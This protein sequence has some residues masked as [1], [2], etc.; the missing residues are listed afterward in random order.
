MTTPLVLMLLAAIAAP[1][2]QANRP[3]D[4]STQRAAVPEPTPQAMEYYRSGNLLWVVWHVTA[5]AIPALVLLT[6]LSARIRN[7]SRRI[8]RKWFFV[9]LVYFVLYSVLQWALE[10]PLA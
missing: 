8:G 3:N 1:A 2:P 4:D 9:V 7:L 6:G 5:L 10:F